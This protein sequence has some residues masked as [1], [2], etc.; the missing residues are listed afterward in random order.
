MPAQ[1]RSKQLLVQGQSIGIQLQ[2]EEQLKEPG[3]ALLFLLFLKTQH[4]TLK[5][6]ITVVLVAPEFPLKL[7]FTRHLSLWIRN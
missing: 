3:Q 6:K 2:P 7:K 4:I 5:R 1:L